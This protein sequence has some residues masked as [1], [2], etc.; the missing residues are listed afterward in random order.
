MSSSVSQ[1]RRVAITSQPVQTGG[2]ITHRELFQPPHD[3]SVNGDNLQIQK[4]SNC[5]WDKDGG[6]SFTKRHTWLCVQVQCGPQRVTQTW[7]KHVDT[8]PLQTWSLVCGCSAPLRPIPVSLIQFTEFLHIK[9]SQLVVVV[10][11]SLRKLLFNVKRLL[12]RGCLSGR[13]ALMN[14]II[15]LH[16]GKYAIKCVWSLTNTRD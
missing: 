6:P 11:L 1:C 10:T 13:E 12:W 5:I 7:Q 4:E 15:Q 9:I 14:D 2:A 16:H 8:A 3:E